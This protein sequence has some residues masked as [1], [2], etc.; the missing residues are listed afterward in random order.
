M[1][2]RLND[3]L[4]TR[5]TAFAEKPFVSYKVYF[6]S[7]KLHD[8][9]YGTSRCLHAWIFNRYIYYVLGSN[10]ELII[11]YDQ[12]AEVAW[13]G[14]IPNA[15]YKVEACGGTNLPP[16]MYHLVH[17][18]ICP[19]MALLKNCRNYPFKVNGII[20][21]ISRNRI[22]LGE[23]VEAKFEIIVAGCP[24]EVKYLKLNVT[25]KGIDQLPVL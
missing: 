15:S 18:P 13:S 2:V 12:I 4:L 6:A 22:T 9:G 16:S 25:I 10:V 5:I 23:V 7:R 11:W 14:V 17:Y 19:K 20:C 1:F 24:V 21:T 3:C 8:R